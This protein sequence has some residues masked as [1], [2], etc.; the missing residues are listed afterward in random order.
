MQSNLDRRESLTLA[1]LVAKQHGHRPMRWSREGFAE[2]YFCGA[3]LLDW[4]AEGYGRTADIKWLGALGQ[5][6][7]E[8]AR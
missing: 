4:D 7:P 3:S 5:Q 2:C 8:T 6:C 1:K